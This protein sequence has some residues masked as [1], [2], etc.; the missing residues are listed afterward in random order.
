MINWLK[1]GGFLSGQKN[2]SPTTTAPNS[3][4]ATK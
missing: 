3:T 1:A 2:I 4:S